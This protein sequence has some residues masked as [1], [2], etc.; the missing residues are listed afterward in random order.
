MTSDPARPFGRVLTAMVTPLAEDGSIDLSG[1][2]QLAAHL[3]DRQAHDGLV[4]LGTT[5]EAPTI[6]DGAGAMSSCGNGSTSRDSCS[7]T[8]SVWLL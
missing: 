4:V 5:G 3:V 2:Q 8:C 1:A 7:R 6:S